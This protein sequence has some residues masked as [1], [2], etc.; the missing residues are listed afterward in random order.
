MIDI[1]KIEPQFWLDDT[2]P[3]EFIKEDGTLVTIDEAKEL[4]KD[5][6][7][8]SSRLNI[9]VEDTETLFIDVDDDNNSHF[10]ILMAYVQMVFPAMELTPFTEL[11]EPQECIY[12]DEE[13]TNFAR[14]Y[15]LIQ[16]L[17]LEVT[18]LNIKDI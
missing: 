4:V 1:Y 9:S 3:R 7:T 15:V 12:V 14:F 6:F 11:Y 5:V 2:K 18:K 17:E 10:T 8:N 16:D 13:D